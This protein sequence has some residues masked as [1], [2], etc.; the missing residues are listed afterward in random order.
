VKEPVDW[1]LLT[2]VPVAS[3]DE[4]CERVRWYSLR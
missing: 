2:T 4:A 3:F 1:M